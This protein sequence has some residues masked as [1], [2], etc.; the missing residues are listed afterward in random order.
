MEIMKKTM[1]KNHGHNNVSKEFLDIK[2]IKTEVSL[3]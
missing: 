2:Q 3:S 1:V